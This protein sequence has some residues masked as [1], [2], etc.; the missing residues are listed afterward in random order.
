MSVRI[1]HDNSLDNF[2]SDLDGVSMILG[3]SQTNFLNQSKIYPTFSS[4]LQI[5]SSRTSLN[6]IKK[7]RQNVI[8]IPLNAC[9]Y[10]CSTNNI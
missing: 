5:L 3:Y 4:G 7:E 6:N 9:E 8:F 1:F 10:F 2:K